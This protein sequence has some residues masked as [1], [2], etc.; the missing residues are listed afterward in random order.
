MET[1]ADGVLVLVER[2]DELGAEEGEIESVPL[3]EIVS[4]GVVD[5]LK[6]FDEVGAAEFEFVTEKLFEGVFVIVLETDMLG[7]TE[8]EGESVTVTL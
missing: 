2:A 8:L 7:E 5:T 6:L 3:K 1:V 4:D